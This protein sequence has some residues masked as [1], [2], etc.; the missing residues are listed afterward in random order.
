M[1]KKLSLREFRK[2]RKELDYAL[3]QLDEIKYYEL[4]N[5]IFS[6]DIS[7]IP[8][9]EWEGFTTC[10]HDYYT[11][12][13]SYINLVKKYPLVFKYLGENDKIG[14]VFRKFTISENINIE[15]EFIRAIKNY[16]KDY[17][18]LHI[19]FRSG[20]N[21]GGLPGWIKSL[22]FNYVSALKD[23]N[24]LMESNNKTFI[25]DNHNQFRFIEGLGIDNLKRLQQETNIFSLDGDEIN[26]H[27]YSSLF[28]IIWNHILFHGISSDIEKFMKGTLSYHDFKKEISNVLE[29]LRHK[30]KL[31]YGNY[32]KIT[33][34]FREEYQEIFMDKDAPE[35]LKD[36]FYGGL[37]DL[38]YLNQHEEYIPFLINKRLSE[39]SLLDI[40]LIINDG[41]HQNFV[42]EYQKRYG[43]EKLLKLLSRFG[44]TI[45]GTIIMCTDEEFN[46]EEKLEYIIMEGVKD[47]II[48]FNINHEYLKENT[49]FYKNYPELFVNFKGIDGIDPNLANML[50][51][52]FYNRSLEFYY[53]RLFP[54]LVNALKDKNLEIP[55]GGDMLESRLN[56][57]FENGRIDLELKDMYGNEKFLELCAKYGRYM[58]NIMCYL[59]DEIEIHNRF[60]RGKKDKKYKAFEEV[61][62]I[63]NSIISRLCISGEMG[64]SDLDAPEF[65]KKEHPELFL[66]DDAP[67]ELKKCF[68]YEEGLNKDKINF[69]ILSQNKDWLPYLKNKSISQAFIVVS[70]ESDSTRKYF[71]LFGEYKGLILGIKKPETVTQMIKDEKVDLMKEWYDKTGCKF[72][73]DYIIMKNI[74][75][76]EADKFLSNT[77]NWNKL[78][79]LEEF[80][81]YI[82]VKDSLLKLAYSFG[83]FDGDTRGFN[84]LYELLTKIPKTTTKEETEML[85]SFDNNLLNRINYKKFKYNS[86][87]IDEIVNYINGFSEINSIEKKDY[88]NFFKAIKKD[89]LDVDFSKNIILQIY[90][91]NEDGTLSLKINQQKYPNVIKFIRNYIG[92]EYNNEKTLMPLKIHQLFGG[93]KMEYNP[94]FREFLL[95]NLD[96]ILANSDYQTY[97]S[98]IQKNFTNIKIAN[99]NRKLTLDLAI[100]YVKESEYEDVEIGND[101]VAEISAIAGYSEEDFEALQRIYNYGKLRVFSSIPRIENKTDKYN[102]EMLRLDD[103]LALAIGTLTNCCQ[104][105][106]NV[107]ES[108]MEHS[109][110]DKNG[111][112][113][114]V[115]DIEGNI[116]S[117]SWVWRNKDVLCFDNIEI[118]RKAFDR[119]DD[120]NKFTEEVYEIY[121]K[122][123]DELI[124][125]DEEVY[126]K[127]YEENKIT[128][129]QY[130]GLR[131][132]KVTVGIGYNDIRE[133]IKKNL[134]KDHDVVRP[135]K[136]VSPIYQNRKLY[137]SDS[138]TQYVLKS[139]NK[140]ET[141][142]GQT[143]QAYSD[144]YELYDDTNFTKKELIMLGKLEMLQDGYS[145]ILNIDAEENLV[146]NIAELY[147][148]EGNKTKVIINPNFAI[149]YEENSDIINIVDLFYNIKVEDMNVEDVVVMQ[150]RLALDQIK[151]NKKIDIS[152]LEEGKKEIYN[153]AINLEEE[154]DKEMG[155]IR[156]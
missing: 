88:I 33:G 95:D 57:H 131:L 127:L 67:H 69:K 82:E 122:A 119:A 3:N 87:D 11:K 10:F 29:E 74:N 147:D 43:K 133:A 15:N 53:I 118:P 8:Y 59:K 142:N 130:E 124:K 85:L 50:E 89:K 121:K 18:L 21:V 72:I 129:E 23:V 120:R 7:K 116:V 28:Y 138:E 68:Y 1:T 41:V 99:S 90:N 101:K 115:R 51:E 25:Y 48:E 42:K 128:K 52:D 37:I 139:N 144:L 79:K 80:T 78:M 94:E 145:E 123:A 134:E 86:F 154:I 40:D 54:Q 16:I 6:Y 126:K 75:I 100:A 60:Y 110:V 105:I 58:E 151:G 108:C 140:Y 106:G 71:E 155:L 12:D 38:E 125:K 148:I 63:I 143:I 27:N 150:I 146:S 149:I 156:K 44:P 97:I 136:F 19:K 30:G 132:S 66:S 61:Q 22:N 153:K 46:D 31:E 62:E 111:R 77:T 2:I 104:E 39:L 93:F 92:R 14:A 9:K 20:V 109:M 103:P 76:S 102:Y 112:V 152:N 35:E 135:I 55:F 4:Q 84:K 141:Y 96:E 36:D 91:Q 56:Y 34:I 45:N 98:S 32:D 26:F 83:V 17:N 70:E 47:N 114:V 81:K 65:L 107:A 137:T 117:Q 5:K 73:P 13:Y 24:D 113:F 64:Y 49:L